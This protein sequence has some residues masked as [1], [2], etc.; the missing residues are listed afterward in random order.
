MLQMIKNGDNGFG[1]R[2]KDSLPQVALS[3]QTMN[4]AAVT[5]GTRYG[6]EVNCVLIVHEDGAFSQNV[7][8][9]NNTAQP[10]DLEYNLD[11]QL[12]VHR[13]SYGQL[14]EGGPVFPPDCE[15]RLEIEDGGTCFI[16]S[17]RLL[18]GNLVGRLF[19]NEEPSALSGLSSAESSGLLLGASTCVQSITLQPDSSVD[20]TAWFKLSPG[21]KPASAPSRPCL[22]ESSQQR[23][24]GIWNDAAIC[25]TYIV[26]RNIDYILGNCCIPVSKDVVGMITDHV[27][28]PLGW[29]R[30]N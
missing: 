7:T 9:R 19:I 24:D 27:A 17:N 23:V 2:I 1:I 18:E 28:L 6:I 12:S 11:L 14:T 16:V 30:D 21:V 8:A 20:I 10:A 5:F 3:H 29:N 15:N 26:R 22:V 13:A 25:K 4:T